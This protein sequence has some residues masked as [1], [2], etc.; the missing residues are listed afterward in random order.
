MK[1]MWFSQVL[2][3]NG[4]LEGSTT[5]DSSHHQD[6]VLHVLRFGNPN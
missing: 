5:Q 3:Q 1:P 6:E 4:Y 2:L